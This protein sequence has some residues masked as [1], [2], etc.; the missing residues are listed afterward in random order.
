MLRKFI[1]RVRR[2]DGSFR[3]KESSVVVEREEI[4]E[5]L[6]SG[7]VICVIDKGWSSLSEQLGVE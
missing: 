4:A 7:R 6:L 3:G 1:T 5:E 2:L